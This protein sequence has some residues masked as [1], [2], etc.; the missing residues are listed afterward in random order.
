VNAGEHEEEEVT[1]APVDLD[2]ED[3]YM[4]ELSKVM[5]PR[6]ALEQL[7]ESHAVDKTTVRSTLAR[8]QEAEKVIRVRAGVYKQLT[9]MLSAA[10][11]ELYKD[12]CMGRSGAQMRE[13]QRT[14][15]RYYTETQAACTALGKQPTVPKSLQTTTN[16]FLN[17]WYD[18]KGE[19]LNTVLR[20]AARQ[21]TGGSRIYDLSFNQAIVRDARLRRIL[22]NGAYAE[23]FGLMAGL[24]STASTEKRD[25]APTPPPEAVE[26]PSAAPPKRAAPR[27]VAPA[28]PPPAPK[29]Q[30]GAEKE[31][32]AAAAPAPVPT[33]E[34][35]EE[36]DESM[37][38]P[39][40]APP[41]PPPPPLR[42]RRAG[43]QP[44]SPGV[45]QSPVYGYVREI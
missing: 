23:E 31:G 39:P 12:G 44:H 30:R 25:T 45:M 41:P 21:F 4:K 28:A 22:R 5:P 13:L 10:P 36:V 34:T 26:A 16:Q 20:Q 42:R 27:S 15:R 17:D 38:T 35:G 29:R 32:A 1:D 33:Q 8:V 11:P 37:V 40:P 9:Y 18:L 6:A 3:E 19:T 2:E 43:L 7:V 24:P 14:I